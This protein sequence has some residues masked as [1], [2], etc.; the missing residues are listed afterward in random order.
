MEL[1]LLNT[2][3]SMEKRMNQYAT[4]KTGNMKACHV[5]LFEK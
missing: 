3:L 1:N 4:Y 2:K 5:N